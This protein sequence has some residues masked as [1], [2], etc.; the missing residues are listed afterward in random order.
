[1]TLYVRRNGRRFGQAAPVEE[2]GDSLLLEDGTDI[3]LEDGTAL[4]LE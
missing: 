4:L 3:L 2:G 1:V